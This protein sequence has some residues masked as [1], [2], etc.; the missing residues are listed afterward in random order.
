MADQDTK[1]VSEMTER[2]LLAGIYRAVSTVRT[3]V[4][5]TF[6]IGIVAGIVLIATSQQSGY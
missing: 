5:L 2:E 6:L 1:P 3:I 4:V